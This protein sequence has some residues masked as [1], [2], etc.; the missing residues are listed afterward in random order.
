MESCRVIVRLKLEEARRRFTQS[1][2][3]A[4][5]RDDLIS[6]AQCIA[7]FFGRV[8]CVRGLIRVKENSILCEPIFNFRP[9]AARARGGRIDDDKYGRVHARHTLTRGET[10]ACV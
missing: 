9:S 10:L 4:Y 1:S 5:Y 6:G 2:I 8:A 7:R 3:A